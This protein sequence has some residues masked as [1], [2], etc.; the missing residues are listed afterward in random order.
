MVCMIINAI[1]FVTPAALCAATSFTVKSWCQDRVVRVGGYE[2]SPNVRF[3][4]GTGREP[5]RLA[6]SQSSGAN[7]PA[8]VLIRTIRRRS[9]F[10]FHPKPISRRP[11]CGSLSSLRNDA[12]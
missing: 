7:D 10:D 11:A 8:R 4:R 12:S 5:R 2:R 6:D 3:S 9:R 1:G